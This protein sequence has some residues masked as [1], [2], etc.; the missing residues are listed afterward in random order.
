MAG[1]QSLAPLKASDSNAIKGRPQD[2][3]DSLLRDATKRKTDSGHGDLQVGD[4]SPLQSKTDK[5]PP[6]LS[7][8]DA[9][10]PRAVDLKDLSPPKAGGTL[11]TRAGDP[12]DR[13]PPRMD[14]RDAADAR[15]FDSKDRSPPRTDKRDTLQARSQNPKD[16][17]PPRVDPRDTL[18]LRS[19]NPKDRSPPRPDQR[20]DAPRKP[21]EVRRVADDRVRSSVDREVKGG[22]SAD[23][24]KPVSS[25][26]PLSEIAVG[27]VAALSRKFDK[28]SGA[29]RLVQRT[30]SAVGRVAGVIEPLSLCFL[31]LQI[32]SIPI[33]CTLVQSRL[34]R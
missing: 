16:R 22:R 11:Q 13:S 8:K 25:A 19:Q 29:I 5:L 31:A 33:I 7:R 4:V 26:L 14:Q 21:E 27:K 9:S 12:K 34:R 10:P 30:E 18:Q 24:V 2:A 20:D 32:E 23:P 6:S 17:S 28:Y 3:K 1:R 15:V